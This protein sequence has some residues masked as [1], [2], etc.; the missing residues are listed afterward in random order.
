MYNATKSKQTIIETELASPAFSALHYAFRSMA[1]ISSK[2]QQNK[3]II[4]S[5][6][7]SNE[8]NAYI[9]IVSNTL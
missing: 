8:E 5:K 6:T 7:Q 1:L 4:T 9:N 2:V 3:I